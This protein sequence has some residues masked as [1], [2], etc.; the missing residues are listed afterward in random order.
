MKRK[1][2]L[3]LLAVLVVIQFIRPS[4]NTSDRESPNEITNYY[5]VPADLHNVLK[6]S[7]Y[8]CHSNNTDYPWY[9]NIQPVGWWLQRHVNQGKR[10]L[11]F[12]EFGSY[13]QK[14]AKHKFDEIE[15]MVREGEMPLA[16]YTLI[17]VEAKLTAEESATIASWASALK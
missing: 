5:K 2:V 11:N 15:E 8:D 1:I 13:D 14:K 12:S 7:W 17:H 6:R 4:R 3:G 9:A 16:S 10:E